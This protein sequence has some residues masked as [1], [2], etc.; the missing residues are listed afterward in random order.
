MQ[1]SK[2]LNL[3]FFHKGK[4]VDFPYMILVKYTDKPDIRNTHPW[5]YMRI[6]KNFLMIDSSTQFQKRKNVHHIIKACFT[7]IFWISEQ[8]VFLL[9]WSKWWRVKFF[10]TLERLPLVRLTRCT[11]LTNTIFLYTSFFF[12]FA[13]LNTLFTYCF[14]S[15]PRHF[16]SLAR[17][18]GL[19]IFIVQISN[20]LFFLFENI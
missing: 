10:D 7:Q 3:L 13:I 20:C 5:Y 2:S 18:L 19:M 4:K 6:L 17:W 14:Y 9:F 15:H 12:R 11:G 16:F 1:A 8:P